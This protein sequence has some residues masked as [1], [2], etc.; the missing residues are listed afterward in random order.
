MKKILFSFLL[1]SITSFTYSQSY[2]DM[3]A[4]CGDIKIERDQFSGESRYTSPLSMSISFKK[5]VNNGKEATYMTL[6]TIS[7]ISTKG[8]GVLINFE[9][10]YQIKKEVASNV[11]E[12]ENGEYVHYVEILLNKNDIS[13]LKNYQIT[14]FTIYMYASGVDNNF[15]YMAYMHC[16]SKI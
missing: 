8:N 12:N 13:L 2:P 11:F 16:L 15:R 4:L 5:L 1:F 3:D 14:T 7:K 10:G 6:S 9:R